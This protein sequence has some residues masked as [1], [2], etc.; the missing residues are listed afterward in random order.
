MGGWD[1]KRAPATS[2]REGEI[3]RFI[4]V[5]PMQHHKEVVTVLTALALFLLAGLCEI[6]GGWLVW[7]WRKAGW[8]WGFFLLGSCILVLYGLVPTLQDQVF[9]RVYAAYGGFFIALSFLWDWALDGQRPDRWDFIGSVIAIAG[10]A[11]IMFMPR[12]GGTTALAPASVA[13]TPQP[14]P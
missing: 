10:V 12:K 8:H 7:K 2:L 4:P 1:H 3:E 5:D 6:G 13:P 11:L 14:Q 9:G